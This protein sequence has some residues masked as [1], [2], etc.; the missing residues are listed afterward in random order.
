M[1]NRAAKDGTK[2]PIIGLGT[3]AVGGRS[4]ADTSRDSEEIAAI[5]KALEMGYRHIDTAEVYASGHSEELVG[6]AIKSMD[7]EQLFITTK[8]DPAHLHE[9]AV[10]KALDGSLKRLEIEYVDMYLIHWPSDSIPLEQSFSA[11]NQLV[12][13]GKIRHLGVSNFSIELL[14][15]A[16]K[17]SESHIVTNQV[18][19]GL[20]DRSYVQNGVLEY[21]RNNGILFT[22]YSPIKKGSLASKVL[23]KIAEKYE[24]SPAQIALAW[25]I[26]REPII[27]I[28]K[29]TDLQHLQDNIDALEISLSTDD[30]EILSAG[31]APTADS[32]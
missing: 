8:V 24:S 28:P 10:E 31:N 26:G 7:R 4:S 21:C 16:R 30:Y 6:R 13:K 23:K 12:R 20:T 2:I 25:V 15:E 18:P 11:L 9:D 1:L 17:Q 3:W 14:E 29:S 32:P 5:Q 22:A 27:T 19:Y